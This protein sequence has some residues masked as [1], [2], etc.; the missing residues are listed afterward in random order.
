MVYLKTGALSV[1]PL[2]KSS[3]SN[4][5]FEIFDSYCYISHDMILNKA[6]VLLHEATKKLFYC[7]ENDIVPYMSIK[8]EPI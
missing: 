8:Q 1:N 2:Q 4:E 5:V 7:I 3:L 6:Y